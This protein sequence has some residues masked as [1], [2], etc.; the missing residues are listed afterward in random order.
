M[1]RKQIHKITLCIFCLLLVLPANASA[2]DSPK[3][4]GEI[5]WDIDRIIQDDPVEERYRTESEMEK[6]FPELFTDETHKT[7]QSV[8]QKN[9]AK[10]QEFENS[11]FL[12]DVEKDDMIDDTKEALFT[13]DYVAP[14]SPSGD[15]D[16]PVQESSLFNNLLIAGFIGLGVIVL[17]GIYMLFRKLA[18]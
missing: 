9:Q 5:Q 6:I 18:D 3:N 2:E 4:K 16:K 10:M 1:L 7:I 14:K 13:S 12:I 11:L 15:H 17:G 8:E